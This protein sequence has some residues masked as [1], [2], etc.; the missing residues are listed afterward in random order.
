MPYDLRWWDQI[1]LPIFL[2]RIVTMDQFCETMFSSYE[3]HNSTWNDIFFRD[4]AILTFC[5]N[6]IADFNQKLLYKL[7]EELYIY[8]SIDAVEDNAEEEHH[9]S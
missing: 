7:H 9:L 2:S 1:E 5:N 6:V 8:D 3:L 4:W